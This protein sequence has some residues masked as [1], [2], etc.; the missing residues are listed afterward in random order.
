MTHFIHLSDAKRIASIRRNGLKAVGVRVGDVRSVHCT[1]V[2]RSVFRTRQ[3]LREL[4]RR[5]T[6][7]IEAVQ[8]YLPPGELVL[9]GRHNV[10]RISIAASEAAGILDAHEDGLGLEVIVPAAI[11][12]TSIRRIYVQK[13]TFGWRFHPAAK[14]SKPFCCCKYCNRGE[15][16]AYRVITD[17]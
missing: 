16:N 2:S 3:W 10:E 17:Q 5:G 13:Q 1:P 9:V 12:P 15:I 6:E 14:G 8:F 11:A 7:T 4:K